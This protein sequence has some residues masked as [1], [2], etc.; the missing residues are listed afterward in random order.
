MVNGYTESNTMEHQIK[1]IL[2][3]LEKLERAVFSKDGQKLT[4]ALKPQKFTG[5]KGGILLLLSK[6]Y[7]NQRRSAPD[8]KSE[9][10][11][12][13]YDYSIQVVQTTLN[14]LSKGKGLLVAHKDGDKKHYVRRK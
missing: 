13:E 8:V 9:L 10:K 6:N 1:E 12:N 14:R 2:L 3:R 7:F 4:Y 5:A 11:K